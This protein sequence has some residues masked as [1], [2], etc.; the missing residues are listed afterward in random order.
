MCNPGQVQTMPFSPMGSQLRLGFVTP[1]LLT[2]HAALASS[3]CC[4]WVGS[5]LRGAHPTFIAQGV[6]ALV[7]FALLGLR[8]SPLNTSA[9]CGGMFL[10]SPVPPNCSPGWSPQTLLPHSLRVAP[11][12]ISWAGRV[13]LWIMHSRA[14]QL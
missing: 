10:R 11:A 4:G 3:R 6:G 5:P 8:R 2:F 1:L 9:C 7:P 14:A 13:L 12:P